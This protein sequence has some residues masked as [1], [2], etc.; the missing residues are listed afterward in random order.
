MEM[1]TLEENLHQARKNVNNAIEQLANA[2]INDSKTFQSAI[3]KLKEFKWKF[4]GQSSSLM[5]DLAIELVEKKALNS[6]IEKPL[7]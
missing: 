6:S 4:T 2:A 5:I 1:T 7:N 3:D